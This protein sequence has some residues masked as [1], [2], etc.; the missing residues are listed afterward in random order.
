MSNEFLDAALR[1]AA[2]N[3]S[4]Y[5]CIYAT[6]RPA[7]PGGFKVATANPATIRRWFGGGYPHNLAIRTGPASGAWVLDVDDRHDGFAALA[8]LERRHGPL[9]LTRQCRTAN[10][11]HFWWCAP[12]PLQCSE[13]RVGRGIGVKSEGGGAM[14]P[15][16]VHPDGVVYE[17]ANDE[18]LARAPDWLLKAT[19]RPPAP[20]VKLPPR[21]HNGPLGA[22]GAAALSREVD[23]L[24]S[25]PEGG[26]NNQ[27]N[28]AS[29]CLHQLV[30]G[31]ELD[32]ADVERDLLTAAQ[33][34]GLL[35]DDGQ[36]QVLATIRSGARA[37]LQHPRGRR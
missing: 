36:R 27:L 1:Y 37:G 12:C 3:F 13:G 31:G 4:V 19:R 18:P 10:G 17:W 24:A 26:R 21:T 15:P 6:K 8:K 16:S 2:Q 29:F 33:A 23:T 7:L 25:T 14:V 35:A 30:A 20:P 9:P 11:V 5:P 34:N 28:R 32:A 22:Y